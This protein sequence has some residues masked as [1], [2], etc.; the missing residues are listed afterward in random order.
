M[1]TGCGSKALTVLADTVLLLSV[2][3]GI[4]EVGGRT[5]YVMDIALEVGHLG[6]LPC[7]GN[8]ALLASRAHLSTLMEGQRTEIT[9]AKAATVVGERELN[10]GNSRHA[11]EI[12]IIGVEI[13]CIRQSVNCVKLL[14]L[15][16]RHGRILHQHLVAVVLHNGLAVY[17]IGVFI[18][19]REG[20]GI[21]RL[22]GLKKVVVTDLNVFKMNRIALGRKVNATADVTDFLN[23]NALIK[24]LCN[25]AENILTHAVGKDVRT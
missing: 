12:V 6:N 22:I 24:K 23:G 4:A 7:L 15:K 16:G 17:R 5:T 11:S 25:S 21:G 1:L 3:G 18:L 9:R 13:P 2:A 19:H 14:P 10:L 20:L 8:N